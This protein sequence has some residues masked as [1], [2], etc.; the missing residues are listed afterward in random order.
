MGRYAGPKCRACR[1]EGVKLFLRGDRCYSAQC[2][3]SKRPQVPGQHSRFRRRATPYA[4]RIREKQKLKRIY[5]VREAQFRRYVEAGKKWK[6][7]TGE[8]ILK[9]LERRLDNVVYRAGFAHSRNQARQI[10]GHGHI[11]VNGRPANIASHLL[12]EGDIVE[13]KPQSRD[14]LRPQIKEAAERRPVPSWVTR[15]LEGLRI[16]V[17]AEPNVEEIEQSVKM[18]LIVEFYSR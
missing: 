8:A 6:G 9:Q 7:V 1:R 11:L 10:V 12:S 13:V 17:A 15:D 18:N 2:P 4:I 14:K 16:Q 3:V 5:G